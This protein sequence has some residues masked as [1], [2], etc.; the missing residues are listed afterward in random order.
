MCADGKGGVLGIAGKAWAE[1][2]GFSPHCTV[3]KMGSSTLAVSGFE[4][5]RSALWN[6]ISHKVFEVLV[7][8]WNVIPFPMY[9]SY[10]V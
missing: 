3:A 10:S 4:H 8:L 9:V 7:G 2:W 1:L 5:V 6:M